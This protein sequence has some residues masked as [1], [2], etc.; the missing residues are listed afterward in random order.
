MQM[1]GYS[2]KFSGVAQVDEYY[3]HESFKGKRDAEFFIYT[4]GRMPRHHR[5]R[6]ERIEWLQKNGLY[7]R[8]LSEEPEHLEEL[9]SEDLDKR[10]RVIW[11]KF[12][13]IL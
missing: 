4:L 9:L 12:L 1:Y 8:L 13:L 7:D 3:C 2:D 11:Y 5:N 6:Q 10:K